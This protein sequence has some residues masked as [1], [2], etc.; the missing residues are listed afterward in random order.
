[1]DKSPQKKERFIAAATALLSDRGY[2]AMT[3]RELAHE[4]GCDKSNIYNYIK[5]KQDL[6]DQ[7]LFEVADKFHKGISEIETSTY[8]AIDKLKEVIRLHV[9]MTFD[10]PAKMN[11]H[12]NEWKFLEENRKALFLKRRKS[13]E[14]K[15]S[16][17]LRAGIQENAFKSG[18]VEFL[19]NCTLSSIRWLYTWKIS[20]KKNLNPLEVEKNITEFI[21]NGLGSDN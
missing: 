4:L 14:K 20:E 13:Y 3:M 1:M 15:I 17:I 21:F 5:S 9:R 6:L 7:L 2:K 11:I 10:N 12:V 16:R 8:P 18:D 19:K